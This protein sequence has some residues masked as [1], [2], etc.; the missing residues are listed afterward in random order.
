MVSAGK[1]R[2][3]LVEL[4]DA[5]ARD[6]GGFG[7]HTAQEHRA[8]AVS[9]GVEPVR[10]AGIL[11]GEHE[12]HH[13]VGVH[14][15]LV[16]VEA[17]L[18]APVVDRLQPGIA[19]RDAP[20]DALG[21]FDLQDQRL[22]G[23]EFE[24]SDDGPVLGGRTHGRHVHRW[25]EVVGLRHRAEVEE[26]LQV[27][28]DELPQRVQLTRD[29]DVEC[30]RTVLLLD[31]VA[32]ALD[33]QRREHLGVP[34]VQEVSH[35]QRR[36]VAGQLQPVPVVL[37]GREDRLEVAVGIDLEIVDQDIGGGGHP[38]HRLQSDVASG[39]PVAEQ[40]VGLAGPEARVHVDAVRAFQAPGHDVVHAGAVDGEHRIGIDAQR[41][42]RS[43]RRAAPSGGACPMRSR[44]GSCSPASKRPA[45]AAAVRRSCR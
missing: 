14:H 6:G 12:A 10:H 8:V 24:S 25:D 21:R 3:H 28:V 34:V 17:G 32:D 11:R 45:A 23:F 44:C 20:V 18:V 13:A 22:I 41:H 42:G 1:R 7:S 5:G 2:A 31:L 35:G 33:L 16:A 36:M 30:H 26:E 40:P 19:Q 38:V 39:A 37:V 43:R 15:R 4:D 27:V 29:R 9:G